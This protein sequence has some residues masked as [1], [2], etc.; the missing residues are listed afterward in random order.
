MT[1]IVALAGSTIKD[2]YPIAGYDAKSWLDVSSV[3]HTERLT[4][5]ETMPDNDILFCLYPTDTSGNKGGVINYYLEVDADEDGEKVTWN[6]KTYKLYKAVSHDFNFLTFNEDFYPITGYINDRNNTDATFTLQDGEYRT[7]QFSSASTYSF[8]YDRENYTITFTDSYNNDPKGEASVKYSQKIMD[9]M[10]PSNPESSRP[11]YSF[12][13]WYVDSACSTRVFFDEA[14]YNASTLTNKMLYSRMPANNLNFYAGWETVWYLIEIDPNGGELMFVEEGSAANQS[15]FFWEPYNGDPIIEYTTVTRS[16]EE[17]ALYGTFFYAKKDRAYYGLT[18]EWD[19]VE[20][21]IKSRRA[22][23]TTSQ[24]DDAR[25]DDRRYRQAKNV[26]RYAGWYEQKEDGTEELYAFGQPVQKNTKLKLHWKHLG[27]Y[28]LHF[29]VGTTGGRLSTGDENETILETLDASVYADSSEILVTRTAIPPEGYAFAGW[30]IRYGDDTIFH[31]GQVFLFDAAY[32]RDVPGPD[33]RTIHQLVLDAVYTQV[34][35]V[36]LTTDANGGTLDGSVATTL[37]LAYPDAPSLITNVND[38]ATQRTVSGMRNHAYGH[39]S[40]GTGYSC[41]VDGVSLPFLGWNTAADGSGTHFDG[42]QYVGVDTLGT[43]DENGRNILYAE[44]GVLV[45]FDKNNEDADWNATAWPTNCVW[46]EAKGLFC[47]TNKLNGFATDPAVPLTSSNSE[48]MF[49][50]WGIK[51]YSGEIEPYD[52]STP[53]TNASITL[54]G[55]WSNRIEVAVHAVDVTDGARLNKDA[56]WLRQNVIEMDAATYK[57]FETDSAGYADP[58][59]NYA[60]AFACL[61]DGKTGHADISEEMAITNVYYNVAAQHVYVTYADGRSEAMPDG[62]EIYFVYYQSPKTIN[63]GYVVMDTHGGLSDVSVRSAAPK[64][65]TIDVTE[66][67]M[68]SDVTQPQYWA[69][70][71]HEY[72]AFAVGA[73]NVNSSAKLH[74]ITTA[75]ESDNE[76]PSLLVKNAWNGYLYSLDGGENWVNC[77]FDVELYVVYFDEMPVIVTLNE[78]TLGAQADMGK[79]FGYSVVVEEYTV[80]NTVI[81]Q[82][83]NDS[84]SSST[85]GSWYDNGDPTTNV[86]TGTFHPVSSQPIS[87]NL[88]DGG[89]EAF[90]IM[91]SYQESEWT[92]PQGTQQGS[93]LNRYYTRENRRTITQTYQR[94]TITQSPAEDFTTTNDGVGGDQKYVYTYTTTGADDEAD[95]SVTFTNTRIADTIPVHVALGENGSVSNRDDLRTGDAAIY[96]VT[97]TNGTDNAATFG[98][99]MPDGFFTGDAGRYSFMGIF[100]ARTNENGVVTA[101]SD[102]PVSSVTFAPM[103]A[104]G[105]FGLYFDGDPENAVGDWEL[106]AVYAEMPRIYYVREGANGALSLVDPLTYQGV[107]VTNMGFGT[108]TVAQ[109]LYATPNATNAFSVSTSPGA[110]KYFVPTF[111]DS[112][113]AGNHLTQSSLAAGP[114]GA[115]N[116]SAMYGV[117]EGTAIHLRVIG[118]ILKWSADG[119]TWGDFTGDPAVYVAYKE[120]GFDLTIVKASLASNADKAADT[121][122]FTIASSNLTD[123]VAHAVSGYSTEEVTPVNGVITLTMTNGS[124][125]TIH[126]LPD[127]P[128]VELSRDRQY[129]ILEQTADDYTLTNTLVNGHTPSTPVANGVQTILYENKTVEFTNIKSYTV[130]FVDEDGRVI[131][132]DKVPYGTTPDEFKSGVEDPTK[133]MD[134]TSIYRFDDWGPTLEPV[135]SNT[136]YTAEYKEIKIPQAT[137]RQDDTNVVVNLDKETPQE[138]QEALVEALKDAGIDILSPDYSEEAANEILN[139]VDPNG[140]RHWENLVTGSDTNALALSTASGEDDEATFHLTAGSDGGQYVDLGYVVLHD[141]RKLEEGKWNRK[142][143]PKAGANPDFTIRLLDDEGKS[144][145]A[146]GL[147]RVYTLII[148]KHDLAITNEIPSTNIVGVL[149]IESTMTNTLAAVPWHM[150]ASDPAVPTNIAVAAWVQTNQLA[151]A[152]YVR[153]LDAA[154]GYEMWQLSDDNWTPFTTTR[155]KNGGSKS[156]EAEDAFSRRLKRGEPVWLTRTDVSKGSFFLIGQFSPDSVTEQIAGGNGESLTPTLLTNPTFLPMSINDLEWRGTPDSGDQIAI[157]TEDGTPTLLTWNGLNWGAAALEHYEKNGRM[158]TRVVR[159]TDFTIPPGRGFWYH[160]KAAGA[161]S[162]TFPAIPCN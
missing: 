130:T 3:K 2:A 95:Q 115:T 61:S 82:Q 27:T 8:Y 19:P 65:A 7:A 89:R 141:L 159:K 125:V 152:T 140:M 5:L 11:G 105:Y 34:K 118:G 36:A 142:D 112:L 48:E 74:L 94:I 67:N 156:A 106:Y 42:G 80:T 30:R 151:G 62:K 157:P 14:E 148:P 50:Y 15:T 154:G 120:P 10:I 123:G 146:T 39:L 143:G 126:A 76:R 155:A 13:G 54:Y 28:R 29:D 41:T 73:P 87:I 57:S 99:G 60:F 137:Q 43:P 9:D 40:D 121:F 79:A 35:T 108:T 33:G 153:A 144:I 91:Y 96:T 53:L 47:Q 18:D 23:Y 70:N 160:R 84:S 32:T 109:G 147:Y 110:G 158:R 78:K 97:V 107:A 44:W 1:N 16:F 129:E 71:G 55:V 139:S 161:L 51:R 119:A 133:P 138:S 58:G 45:Y 150:L 38:S 24:S 135:G 66:Y 12:S 52:F 6:G 21:N 131:S 101:I 102:N 86:T 88:A 77:G 20:N 124:R 103:G 4:A 162:V 113:H 136:T 81:Q 92:N 26:Y 117:A 75:S 22:Y 127:A 46:D 104:D 128:Q 145:G 49:R 68:A 149:E 90:T 98:N 25:V 72:Y 56:D 63:I 31:P 93:W 69:Y 37:P 111:L 59:S 100:Y 17:S 116:K 122:T 114:I 132:S 64:A 85:S 134:E 83:R